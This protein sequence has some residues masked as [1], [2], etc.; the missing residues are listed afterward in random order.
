MP[1]GNKIR[2]EDVRELID[3][4]LQDDEIGNRYES[5]AKLQAEGVA[6]LHNILCRHDFA[7]LADEVGMGKT[8]Q[9]IGLAAVLWNLKPDARIVIISPRA[10]LQHKWVRDYT[11]FVQH[12]YRRPLGG[13]GDDIVKSLIRNRPSIKPYYCDNLYEFIDYLLLPGRGVYFLR[14]TSFRRPAFFSVQDN[15]DIPAVWDKQRA[16]MK[17]HGLSVVDVDLEGIDKSNVSLKFNLAFAGALNALLAEIGGGQKA[18]D[19]IIV[20]EAQYLRNPGNQGNRVF[21]AALEGRVGKWLFM[22]ATPVHSDRSNIKTIV[23]YVDPG[24]LCREDLKDDKRLV[25]L[26]Q[27]FMIRRPRKFLVQSGDG[28]WGKHLYRDHDFKNWGMKASK[29][30]HALAMALVQKKLVKIL[31]QRNNRFRIGFLSSFESLQQSII[32]ARRHDDAM[33][34]KDDFHTGEDNKDLKED[35]KLPPDAFFISDL[36]QTFEK[37]FHRPLPHPKIDFTVE[38]L[39]KRAFRHNEKFLVFCRRINA[40]KELRDRLD[41]EYH[42]WVE[43]RIKAV[44]GEEL[45]WTNPPKVDRYESNET[46]GEYAE[47][48]DSM[49]GE[50]ERFGFRNALQRGQWLFNYRQTFR[51]ERRNGTFFQ[52]NWLKTLCRIKG[53]DLSA[54]IAKIPAELISRAI[55]AGTRLQAGVPRPLMVH[56]HQYLI[57]HLVSEK[58]ELLD[59]DPKEADIW[60]VFFSKLYNDLTPSY[61]G[62]PMASEDENVARW[63]EFSG[64]WDEWQ[65]RFEVTHDLYMGISEKVELDS[66]YRR[67]IVKNWIGQSFRLSD[68]LLDIYFS[69]LRSEDRKTTPLRL[70]FDYLT[71]TGN[72]S[73]QGDYAAIFRKRARAWKQHYKIIRMNCFRHTSD[74]LDDASFAAEGSYRELDSPTAVIAVVGGGAV[75]ETAIRQFKTP[76]YPQIIVCTDV[77][78]EG[79]D[80]HTFCDKVVH[81]GVAWT[82]GDLEQR[83]GRVDRYFSKIERRLARSKLPE[84]EKLEIM[85]PHMKDTLEKYQIANVRGKVQEA[86]LI[87]DN[88]LEDKGDEDKESRTDENPDAISLRKRE[89]IDCLD[90]SP[91][92]P[93]A[94]DFPPQR[95][96]VL[97]IPG[98]DAENRGDLLNDIAGRIRAILDR[99]GGLSLKGDPAEFTEFKIIIDGDGL[100]DIKVRWDFI[101]E[102]GAYGLRFLESSELETVWRDDFSYGYERH[103]IGNRYHYFRSHRLLLNLNGSQHESETEEAVL[104]VCDY[105]RG[106]EILS[107]AWCD[108]DSVVELLQTTLKVRKIEK[109]DAHKCEVSVDFGR[110]NQKITLYTYDKLFLI[111][112]TVAAFDDIR[113]HHLFGRKS[114]WLERLREWCLDMNAE[115]T[116]GFFRV[117]DQRQQLF[118]CERVFHNGRD[119]GILPEIIQNVAFTADA[120]ESRLTGL[121]R[122]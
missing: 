18:I 122:F 114:D 78:K 34:A 16:K 58:P 35:E 26:M 64:F 91:F 46:A 86:A 77:L 27:K 8:Y 56:R 88:F 51:P 116:L 71:G 85:Y 10:N 65:T 37:R 57:T 111:V 102:I 63:L 22:S 12:N 32:S 25:K 109:L 100:P 90:Q 76:S 59:L 106:G 121:D 4:G 50:G 19:L 115:H 43:K 41:M 11:N 67:E 53:L 31:K 40:V 119:T 17:S 118:F 94:S 47:S 39:S 36:S 33:P 79:E 74:R 101:D 3:F 2:P 45:N 72:F 95:H 20:D 104:R 55:A 98:K 7:F 120:Y 60:K 96:S 54:V 108:F 105:F 42:R 48:H 117:D 61:D 112:S 73:D 89:A 9:A 110:R 80:L 87:L 62:P 97:R 75:N 15:S 107:R 70:L 82:S 38:R 30:L 28:E 103:V 24:F 81:Y 6:A 49:Q 93:K 92:V 14:H 113:H 66:L 29:P 68:T 1:F 84:E 13:H 44:W 5:M 23:D 83:V 52:E 21:R 69:E 99:T